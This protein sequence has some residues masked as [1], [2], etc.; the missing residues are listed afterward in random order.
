MYRIHNVIVSILSVHIYRM[1]KQVG[2]DTTYAK[3]VP[4][5]TVNLSAGVMTW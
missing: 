4:R 3:S 1:S 5:L 2:K